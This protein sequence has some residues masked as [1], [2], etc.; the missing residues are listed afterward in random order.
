[1]APEPANTHEN[2]IA[3]AKKL[4]EKNGPLEAEFLEKFF[5]QGD[6]EDLSCYCAEEIA[7]IAHQTFGKFADHFEGKHRIDILDP[8]F[9]AN[10]EAMLNQISIIELHNVNKPFLVDSI[11]GEL[12]NAGLEIH[13]VLHPI[14]NLQRDKDK[15]LTALKTRRD[16]QMDPKLKR[17]S[18]IHVHVSRFSSESKKA[19]LKQK[20]GSILDDVTAVV[21]D[22]K[23]M[24]LRLEET[25]AIL[26]ITPPPLPQEDIEETVEF[27]RWLVD[28]N[29]TLLGIRE[30]SFDRSSSEGD[31]KRTERPGLGLLRNPEV[32]V[33][34]RGNELVTTTP[35]IRD[36]L[37]RPEPLF[38]TK[39]NV[40]T[41]VHRRTYMDYI[42]LKQYDDEG[43]LT[44]EMRIVGLFTN[45]AYNRSVT[46]IPFLRRKVA[47][48]IDATAVDPAGHSGKALLNVFENYPRDE[49]FQVDN[50]TL[51]ANGQEILRLHQRPRVRVLSRVDKFDR[52]VSC[53]VYVPRDRYDTNARI[54]IGAFLKKIY[55]G[56]ISAVYPEFPDGPLAR[57][58]YIIGRSEGK[59]PN[60]S[61]T[62]LEDAVNAIVRTWTDSLCEVIRSKYPVKRAS[63]NINRYCSA[64]SDAYRD[65]FS[66]ED[67]LHDI[68]IMESM[69]STIDTAI[70]FYRDE[71]EE[72]H[73]ISLKIFHQNT[74]IPLSERVPILE[75]MGFRVIDERSYEIVPQDSN[76]KLWL[77]DMDLERA[78][79]KAIPFKEVQEDLEE[80]FIAVWN[81]EA[82]NDG[83][84]R[85]AMAAELPWRDITILRTI[86]RYLRQ[87][88]IPYDQDYMWATLN[89]YPDMAALII[90][91][92]HARFDPAQSNREQ[93]CSRLS[94]GFLTAL[95]QVE[96]LDD[97]RILRKFHNV[98]KATL[99]TNFYQRTTEGNFKPTLSLK[100]DPRAMDDMPEPR[101]FREIFVYSPRVEGLHLRFGK[102]ARGGL[103]WSDRPQDFRTEVLGLVKAQQVKN[104]VIVPVGSK[105][106]FVPKHLPTEGGREAYMAEG[107]ASYKLFISALLDVTDNIEGQTIVPPVNVTRH[108]DDDPYLVVAADKG[109]ATFSDIANSISE[110]HDFWLGDAFASGGSA[111]YDHKKMGITARGAWEAVKRH[112]RE[113]DRDIQTESFTTV[114][115]GDMSGDVF[116]NGMLLSKETRLIAAFDHRDIFI[117]PDPDPATSWKE[118]KRVFD[119][120]RSSWR[121]YNDKL[122]SKGGGIFSRTEKSI[123]LSREAK[124]ALGISKTKLTP[125]ELMKAI[126]MAPVDLLWFGGIGTYIRA[127]F[128]TDAD[129]DDRA[130]DAIR[131][132][133]K[134]LRVK[135]IG[136]G[137]NLG[138]TQQ[139]RIEFLNLGG[140]CNSDAIDNSAGVNSSDME[141]NIK[142][143]LGAAIRANKLDLAA[144]NT[145][146]SDMTDNVA[147]LVLRNNYLQTLSI[148]LSEQRGMEDFG[149]QIRLME[150]LEESGELDRAV[151]FLPDNE[152]IKEAR[153]KKQPLTRAEI[154]VLLAYAKNSLY[155][156]LL[157]SDLPD[158]D[159]LEQELMRYFPEK[160]RETYE[161][162]IK[163]HRLRREIISTV[164][165]NSM[166][167]RG[168]ATLIPRIA[169]KTGASIPEIARAYIMVR[170]SFDLIKLNASIDVLDN[171]IPGALQLELYEEVQK[172]LLSEIEWFM[173][174]IPA[175]ASISQTVALYS[176]GIQKL[177]TKLE[178]YLPQDLTDQQNED[179]QRYEANGVPKALASRIANL[180]LWAHIPDIVQISEQT[181]QSLDATAKAYYTI[182]GYFKIGRIDALAEELD[183]SDYYESLALDR[184]RVSLSTAHNQMTSHILGLA[185]KTKSGIENWNDKDG[186]AIART[187]KAVEAITE[188]DDLTVAKFSV[189]AGLLSDLAR[190]V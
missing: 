72:V 67:A 18:L 60:P 4:A 11:M 140:R 167:N 71:M 100:L 32:R 23:P 170:D 120:G 129:A 2:L 48:I 144:R 53:L 143:A 44:G 96:N 133:P 105:G 172:L 184:I 126:L 30:Y 125:Q 51:L 166:I 161:E 55:E 29:F 65:T 28:N 34:R 66:P 136:E 163:S 52:F 185:S 139:A 69:N 78:S 150:S 46:N 142:I 186:D 92:F 13:L 171:K 57:V 153:K 177:S 135:V 168:G 15:K 109:T 127:S 36:F 124:E 154:G 107:I 49:L 178:K 94:N 42:G 149:Y 79:G 160:M 165:T 176:N 73:K 41:T 86:S 113:M 123:S 187:L 173:R 158:I 33:L 90:H 68:S 116:G 188:S 35:E 102:V 3:Q 54:R 175:A 159:F 131:V 182:A 169:D 134:D 12:Q 17:E 85:L 61:K 119:L 43:Q 108:D 146:L 84:N 152:A 45:T 112:F 180:S 179:K 181:G 80:C 174:H 16:T 40:K 156:D 121:D 103:R 148:S 58:H 138:V 27:L 114:G 83:Y 117:D 14:M 75:N 81:G 22:W 104:A 118:R 77:H 24:L 59:T 1:M 132:I 64:F 47:S 128:E 26:K 63:Q 38:I 5:D 37:M 82:E 20:L 147:N 157:H 97:D 62:E 74:P 130:N 8:K 155:E 98:I 190:N 50:E 115:V 137:A 21:S 110:D 6:R 183:V 122:I 89:T 88:R 164:I 189:A 106:G 31:L 111:G 87:I 9:P 162:E 56:R 25:I 10:P 99:R 95:E 7:Q 19:D 70:Q 93:E 101:P 39:A 141:V 76:S 91:L 145:L 151:E